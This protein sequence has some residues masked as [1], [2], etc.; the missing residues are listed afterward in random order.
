MKKIK[1]IGLSLLLLVLSSCG[2]WH[3]QVY[4]ESTFDASKK[5]WQLANMPGVISLYKNDYMSVDFYTPEK[6]YKNCLLIFYDDFFPPYTACLTFDMKENSPPAIVKEFSVKIEDMNGK[7]IYT[8]Q[9]YFCSV[10]ANAA[11][12]KYR[13]IESPK[14][15]P[16]TI[17]Y[18]NLDL[19]R[20][21]EIQF[22][23]SLRL[24]AKI[25]IILDTEILIENIPQIIHKEIILNRHKYSDFWFGV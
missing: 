20:Q 1:I 6:I 10:Y 13:K 21:I 2:T 17:I 19:N 3:R 16:L 24:P 14:I 25:K 4:D 15:Q 12:R 23:R 7:E 18:D 9:K 5:E 11:G 22:N 8:K